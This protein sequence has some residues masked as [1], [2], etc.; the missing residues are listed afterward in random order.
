M[1]YGLIRINSSLLVA[2]QI[3]SSNTNYKLQLYD[4][5]YKCNNNSSAYTTPIKIN[6]IELGYNVM[7]RTEYFV[8]L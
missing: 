1:T 4:S 6:T 8:S 3:V 5:L 2:T 7:K